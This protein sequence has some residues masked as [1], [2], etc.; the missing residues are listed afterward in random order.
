[1]WKIFSVPCGSALYKFHCINC[2]WHNLHRAKGCSMQG[3]MIEWLMNHAM[4]RKDWVR[5]R[6]TSLRTVVRVEVRTKH[7]QDTSQ[8]VLQLEK[9]PSV[10]E[11]PQRG[12]LGRNLHLQ[13]RLL[14]SWV[15]CL[16]SV[17]YPEDGVSGFHRNVWQRVYTSQRNILPWRWRQ[18]VNTKRFVDR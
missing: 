18:P 4:R 8:G 10:W 17:S 13:G 5:P 2:L 6:R 3:R 14:S 9:C 15:R 7:Y 16:A 12:L 11:T 1:M